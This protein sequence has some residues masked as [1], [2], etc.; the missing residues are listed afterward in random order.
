MNL[1]LENANVTYYNN[2]LESKIS[3]KIYKNIVEIII[4]EERHKV[5]NNNQYYKLNRK[6]LVCVDDSIKSN[7][8]SAQIWND[9]VSV[10]GFTPEIDTLKLQLQ[11]LLKYEFN[12]LTEKII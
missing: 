1:N 2:F 4:S 7:H 5:L 12:I 9:S 6:T 3:K 8:V 10:I 11:D